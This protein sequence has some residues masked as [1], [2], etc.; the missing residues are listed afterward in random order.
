MG[1]TSDFYEI[2]EREYNDRRL[3]NAALTEERRTAVFKK[4]PRL[5]EID[6]E[7][8]SLYVNRAISRIG[9]DP[10]GSEEEF[11][12]K[13]N[14]LQDERRSLLIGAGLPE[15]IL[16]PV[17]TC[18]ECRDT[19]YVDDQPCSCFKRRLT[20]LMYDNS[21]IRNSLEKENFSTFNLGY[22]SDEPDRETGYSPLAAARDALNKAH[23][24]IDAFP[25]G[26]GLF[27]YG[28]TGTGKTFLSN[29]IARELIDRGY[30]VVYLSAVRF[31]NILADAAFGKETE[32]AKI[33]GQIYSCDLLI[34]DDLGTEMANSL[35]QTYLFD[36]INERALK[37]K[38]TVISSNKSLDELANTYSERI[39]SRIASN[40][41]II[42]L[43]GADIRMKKKL[44]G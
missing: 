39:L 25:S 22:Y 44:E 1:I 42:K 10:A 21:N 13:V 40:Y 27:I 35:T 7:L 37:E 5:S 23:D 43:I 9:N 14:A 33:A 41:R 18:S 29:C 4:I 8:S 36:C 28:M 31:F 24:F 38:A 34:I 6:G 15:D 17:Y 19:G 3:K 32:D 26:G 2:I 16:E 30:T 11:R 12:E 20:E